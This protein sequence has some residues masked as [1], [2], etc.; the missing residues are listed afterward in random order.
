MRLLDREHQR[1][2]VVSEGSVWRDA[3]AAEGVRILEREPG[4]LG[5]VRA[6]AR[7]LRGQRRQHR[8]VHL[9]GRAVREAQA[10]PAAAAR[11][12]AHVDRPVRTIIAGTLGRME[13]RCRQ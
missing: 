11:Q 7:D 3:Y 1:G 9:V 6:D 10:E 12:P 5:P 8:V 13:P 2:Q 4:V